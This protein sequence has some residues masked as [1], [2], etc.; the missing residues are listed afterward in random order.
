MNR[1][2]PVAFL[3]VLF[4]SV[5]EADDWPQF[6]GP[7]GS[8]VSSDDGVPT[9]WSDQKNLQWKVDL[10]GKGFSSP[11]VVGAYVLVTCYSD[12]DGDLEK[13]QRHLVCVDRRDGTVTWTAT[14]P[15]TVAEASGP[16]F[17]TRHGF[18]SH[19]PVSDGQRVY[20]LFGGTGV[21]AFDLGGEELWRKSVGAESAA[22]FG[23]GSSPILYGD[24]LIVTAGS[25]SESIRAL[26]KLT[27]EELWKA[28][29]ATL[30]RCYSTPVIAANPQGEDELLLSVPYE[31]W[32]LAPDSGKLKWYAETQVDMNA[33]PALVVGDGVVYA[34]GGR[35]GGRT[36]VRIGGKDDVTETNVV[37]STNEGA[38]V[39]SPVLHEGHLYWVNDRG[40]AI[41]VDAATGEEVAKKR[42][43]GQF[44]ASVVVI[45]DK[46]YA[47]S[48]FDGTFVLTATPEME[49][50]AHN[51]LSDESDFSGSPAVSDG[52]FILRSD[53]SLYCVGAE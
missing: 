22:M 52:Q 29:A 14:V 3:A 15:S 19:T 34:I 5:V 45:H 1:A 42:L 31:I 30:S 38:Y 21:V 11:I 10:P 17:G 13:L 46:L 8:G 4:V 24:S 28:E 37:W 23:S 53:T 47:V 7:G 36:A 9:E 18:A 6:R 12:A 49:E 50:I 27:G 43:D 25:E 16:A 33:V 35:G 32:S 51:R 2:H 40:V 41:C 20:V 26:D 39:P 48:R 44:Y